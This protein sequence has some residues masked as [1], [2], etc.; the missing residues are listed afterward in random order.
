MKLYFT[1]AI[2]QRPKFGCYYDQIVETVQNLGHHIQHEH[3]TKETLANIKKATEDDLNAHYRKVVR[4]ISQAD[5]VI[6]E[7][8]FP[9]TLNV[10]HEISLAL[11]RNKPTIVLYKKGYDSFFLRGLN[12][13]KLFLVEY[14]PKSLLQLVTACVN[15]AK[16]QAETRFNF[17]MPPLYLTYLDWAATQKK[18]PRSV[19]LRD[20]LEKD[21]EQNERYG[22]G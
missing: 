21:R 17:F 11:E 6:V 16:E 7:A 9:S 13:D 8:S 15:Y 10:G 5:I 2:V 4:W 22:V 19:Y 3:I 18:L 20:L 1:A 12:S 14:T